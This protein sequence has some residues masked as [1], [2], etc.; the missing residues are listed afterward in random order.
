MS[1]SDL[2]RRR[3]QH[4]PHRRT[5]ENAKI[6]QRGDPA[7]MIEAGDRPLPVARRP[8]I[9]HPRLEFSARDR[10]RC[11]NLSRHRPQ[12]SRQMKNKLRRACASTPALTRTERACL[13]AFALFSR[14]PDEDEISTGER[15]TPVPHPGPRDPRR[16]RCSCDQAPPNRGFTRPCGSDAITQVRTR[17]S[18]NLGGTATQPTAY[19]AL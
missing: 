16:R 17:R 1:E 14:V 7:T 3:T 6:A 18:P 8:D 9:S 11:D 4:T 13:S 15:A 19:V 12:S 5:S 2:L 10:D